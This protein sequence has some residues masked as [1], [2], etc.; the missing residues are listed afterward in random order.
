MPG[1][2]GI[3]MGGPPRGHGACVTGG[4]S[5]G[6]GK[7]SAMNGACGASVSPH[8]KVQDGKSH[9]ANIGTPNPTRAKTEKGSY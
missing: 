9:V 5:D 6:S 2:R 1:P 7:R 8:P 4:K 3:S